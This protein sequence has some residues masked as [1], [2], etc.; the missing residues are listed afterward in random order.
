[1]N[2]H[3]RQ[4]GI[5]VARAKYRAEVRV[6]TADT[7][8]CGYIP[9][10]GTIQ[11]S[12]RVFDQAEDAWDAILERLV[13]VR[14]GAT[15]LT[16]PEFGDV[17]RHDI[18]LIDGRRGSITER[19]RYEIRAMSGYETSLTHHSLQ[20]DRRFHDIQ[21]FDLLRQYRD[22]APSR[23]IRQ[24]RVGGPYEP[25]RFPSLGAAAEWVVGALNQ[26]LRATPAQAAMASVQPAE[27]RGTRITAL[28][29]LGHE[30]PLRPW[31][32]H[33]RHGPA[34]GAHESLWTELTP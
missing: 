20:H 18:E 21:V 30:D 29:S 33:H 2:T 22:D 5:A 25:M 9:Y 10:V 8:C 13:L 11:I 3:V 34:D 17:V 15:L 24:A 31:I 28:G 19:R 26:A 27:H 7:G 1:M 32:D 4:Q 6:A 14:P 12:R 16:S 23:D